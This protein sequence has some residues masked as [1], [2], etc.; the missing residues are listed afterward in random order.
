MLST[1]GLLLILVGTI[2]LLF[3]QFAFFHEIGWKFRDA[4]PSGL[5]KFFTRVGG[6]IG[7]AVGLSLFESFADVRE[8]WT[9]LGHVA[10]AE[11]TP[12]PGGTRS[13][14]D[15][16]P[17]PT[18]PTDSAERSNA[19]SVVDSLVRDSLSASSAQETTRDSLA[20]AAEYPQ[21]LDEY[22]PYSFDTTWDPT[23][24]VTRR[25]MTLEGRVDHAQHLLSASWP[26]RNIP[27]AGVAEILWTITPPSGESPFG[28]ATI[29]SVRV[30]GSVNFTLADTTAAPRTQARGRSNSYTG[31][32]DLDAFLRVA[33]AS[34]LLIRA[35]DGRNDRS[36]N[37]GDRELAAIRAFA[38]SLRPPM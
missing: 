30:N 24:G 11:S 3:P 37:L 20:L 23:G 25:W 36:L 9:G 22:H 7:L 32:L 5:Y 31:A 18:L 29:V 14:T 6:A 35:S 10:P 34:Y 15:L 1:F 27:D 16:P 12:A 17:L 8:F 33:N 38:S 21:P 28:P 26:G 4:E 2:N 13:S 19:P